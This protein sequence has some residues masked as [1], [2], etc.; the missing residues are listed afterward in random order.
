MNPF[1]L[2]SFLLSKYNFC[3][4]LGYPKAK[5]GWVTLPDIEIIYYFIRIRNSLFLFY[6][7]CHNTKSLY[8]IQY[9]LN[10]SCAKTLACKHKTSL[11]EIS[12]K[13]AKDFFVKDSSK[14]SSYFFLSPYSR[15]SKLKDFYVIQKTTRVWNLQFIQVDSIFLHLEDLYNLFEK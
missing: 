12:K 4:I 11:R 9:I 13:F 14:K 8:R 5:S 2:L 10:L 15:A 6:S 3:N 7:G 1:S